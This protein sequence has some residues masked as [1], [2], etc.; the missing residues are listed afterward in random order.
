MRTVTIFAVVLLVALVS[1]NECKPF[2]RHRQ[3]NRHGDRDQDTDRPQCRRRCPRP[4][5]ATRVCASI[6]LR[7][8]TFPS[9]CFVDKIACLKGRN[10]TVIGEGRCPRLCPALQV[11]GGK[12]RHDQ[13]SESEED[14]SLES[15][16]MEDGTTSGLGP[17][18]S[19]STEQPPSAGTTMTN[20]PVTN[21]S[22]SSGPTNPPTNPPPGPFSSEPTPSSNPSASPT[23]NGPSTTCVTACP[24]ATTPVCG[25]DGQTYPS[26]C[27]LEAYAC[28]NGLDTLTVASEGACPP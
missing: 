20:G 25:T 15:D 10:I 13:E 28:A 17:V 18:T 3:G 22:V 21:P 23:V 14:N 7:N 1:V 5:P 6:G 27:V 9:T 12:G 2:G 24:V 8:L 4:T 16:E 11:G 19:P 26:A